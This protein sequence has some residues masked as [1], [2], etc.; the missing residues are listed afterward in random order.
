MKRIETPPIKLSSSRRKLRI[1]IPAIFF[2]AAMCHQAS[3]HSV[4]RPETATDKAP[5]VKLFSVNIDIHGKVTNEEGVPLVGVSV[6]VG[7][8]TTGTSTGPDGTYTI[9]APEEGT[10]N[11]SYVGYK[12]QVVNVSSRT[13]ID[14]TMEKDVSTLSDIVVIGYGTQKKRDLTGSIAVVKGEDIAKQPSTNPVASLQGKVAGLTV[15]NSGQAGSSPTVRIRG[16]N[17]TNNADP[18]YVVDGILQTNID[19]LNS[20]DI[21][22]VEVLKDPSSFAI[23]G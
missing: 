14:I 15:V 7:G 3:A 18:L 12:S 2:L 6:T 22:S 19:Y 23:Y 17:S 16:V 10:L 11:F 20:A 13:T 5:V 1:L 21:E 9:N 8:S 4:L